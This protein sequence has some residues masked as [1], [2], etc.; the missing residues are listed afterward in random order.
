M[1]F[2]IDS[3]AIIGSIV[4]R[5]QEPRGR[6]LESQLQGRIRRMAIFVLLEPAAG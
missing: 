1:P 3:Q 2:A 6:S 5:P 4:A